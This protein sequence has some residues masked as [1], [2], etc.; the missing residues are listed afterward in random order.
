MYISVDTCVM[1]TFAGVEIDRFTIVLNFMITL[2]GNPTFAIGD[3]CSRLYFVNM[4]LDK[5]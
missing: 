3:I 4:V 1:S 5:V 2:F